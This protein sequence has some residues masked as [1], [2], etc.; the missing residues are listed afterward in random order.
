MYS[1]KR[2]YCEEDNRYSFKTIFDI[3]ATSNNANEMAILEKRS[4]SLEST[5]IKKARGG[6][7]SALESN[8]ALIIVIRY[9]L[10]TVPRV[11][12]IADAAIL[13]LPL[14]APLDASLWRGVSNARLI[15]LSLNQPSRGGC[16]QQ[17]FL[18]AAAVYRLETFSFFPSIFVSPPRRPSSFPSKGTNVYRLEFF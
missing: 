11:I 9:K 2:I 8:S 3:F 6:E 10:R 18:V 12:S 14:L 4:S 7:E 13:L 17:L 5:R 15:L 1:S 16:S